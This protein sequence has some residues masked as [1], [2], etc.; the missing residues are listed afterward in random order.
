M[1]LA[2]DDGSIKL[3]SV[4]G[5][6]PGAQYQ[7]SLAQAEGRSLAVAWHPSG[8]CLYSGGTDG[9]IHCWEAGTGE[10]GGEWGE[11]GRWAWGRLLSCL[12]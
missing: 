1:A 10:E 7:R 11:A 2:C 9:C 12:S 3:F 8:K 6:L 4:E 5:G